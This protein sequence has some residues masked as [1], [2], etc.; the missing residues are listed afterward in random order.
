[1]IFQAK[2]SW[3]LLVFI[4]IGLPFTSYG[5]ASHYTNTWAVH[6]PNADQENVNEIA[7]R[8]GMINL[9]QVGAVLRKIDEY[10]LLILLYVLNKGSIY[11]LF[12]FSYRRLA[13]LKD[14]I[15]FNIALTREECDE[16]LQHTLRNYPG[17]LRFVVLYCLWINLVLNICRCR[18]W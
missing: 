13:R 16:K 5:N 11:K 17:S 7:Q 14:I 9:G 18:G 6:I 3:F 15:I 2:F 12:L 10:F 4:V 8:H 1:M